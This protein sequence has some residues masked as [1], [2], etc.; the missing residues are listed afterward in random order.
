MAE[1][2]AAGKEAFN[3]GIPKAYATAP[4]WEPDGPRNNISYVD[5]FTSS[6]D[7]VHQ[8]G[9]NI[10]H[11]QTPHQPHQMPMQM[12][13]GPVPPG[14]TPPNQTPRHPPVQ[15]HIGQQIP[16]HYDDHRM[17]FQGTTSSPRPT[18][19]Y[20]HYPHSQPPMPV[21]QQSAGYSM[22]GGIPMNMRTPSAGSAPQYMAHS[23]A[24]MGSQLMANQGSSG[25]YL[26][27]M[28]PPYMY[29]PPQPGFPHQ[30]GPMPPQ[31]PGNGF[32]SPR[33]GAPAPMMSH[34]GSQQGHQPQQMYHMQPGQPHGPPMYP[35]GPG[36]SEFSPLY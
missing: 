6:V 31:G 9:H 23:G 13:H 10:M 15:P 30:G 22:P 18:P 3:A 20:I 1:Q 34:Q 29:S 14:P 27:H 7:N 5:L 4:I 2:K 24:P 33:V 32:S 35:P 21:Y 12:Q 11:H 16:T 26:P 8:G 25:Q 17:P 36:P 28:N 19:S